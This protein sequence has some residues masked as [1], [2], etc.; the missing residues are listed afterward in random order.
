MGTQQ[1]YIEGFVKRANEYGFNYVQAMRL[2]K[3]AAVAD[4][5]HTLNINSQPVIRPPKPII[6]KDPM[7]RGH[8]DPGAPKIN[9]PPVDPPEY[10][11]N[12]YLENQQP[13]TEHEIQSLAD[14]PLSSMTP[15]D[16]WTSGLHD[17]LAKRP[18]LA[19]NKGFYK[20]NYTNPFAP[21]PASVSADHVQNLVRATDDARMPGF[22]QSRLMSIKGMKANDPRVENLDHINELTA[23]IKK[24][25]PSWGNSFKPPVANFERLEGRDELDRQGLEYQKN[26]LGTSFKN[27]V[28]ARNYAND[29]TR[30]QAPTITPQEPANGVNITTGL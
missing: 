4:N 14:L 12:H 11:P 20:S 26:N 29:R 1:A 10:E 16:H 30:Q 28:S 24:Y 3:Q 6:K 22:N 19:A 8:V 9:I 17:I 23:H 15:K 5:T 25:D 7:L 13:P 18:V 2:L 21:S 27:H